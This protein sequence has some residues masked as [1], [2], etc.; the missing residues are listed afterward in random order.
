MAKKVKTAAETIA[1]VN[2]YSGKKV[3]A[4]AKSTRDGIRLAL[5]R[6]RA[7]FEKYRGMSPYRRHEIL[8]KA[9]S[10]LSKDKE[11]MAGL[12]TSE[13]GKPI[14][15]S[16]G[17]ISR[18]AFVLEQYAEESLRMNGEILPCG[19]T[20][21]EVDKK[22][23]VMRKPL[24][25][26]LCITP[27]N[28]PLNIAA[29]KVGAAFASGNAVIL[30]PSPL[31]C[32]TAVRFRDI[33]VSAGMPGELFGIVHGYK[34]AAEALAISDVDMISFTGSSKN[35]RHLMGL[36]GMKKITLELGGNA[37]LIVYDDADVEKAVK[38][39]IDQRFRTAGQRCTAAKRLFLHEKIK[40]K[41]MTRLLA[42]TRLLKAGN[43]MSGSCDLCC[44]ITEESAACVEA[45]I[46][47][48]VKKG[49]KLIYGGR[50]RGNFIAPAILESVP[51]DAD[52]VKYETF[53]PVLPVF[54]FSDTSK[55]IERVNSSGDG[56]QTGVF[57]QRLDVI[58][59]LYEEIHSGA[60]IVNDGPGFR[61]ESL[62]FGGVKESGMGREGVRYA[63]EEMTQ[64]TSLII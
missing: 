56:L 26:I 48:A 63:M 22:A 27:F 12:I 13:T 39:C 57:T 45:R 15:E 35:G 6:A 54:T 62:P 10:L 49:A 32:L 17:E 33:M 16:R 29:H 55:L 60:L 42:E 50:R 2:P 58:K 1:V 46:R 53:G 41:F 4:V 7:A 61:L 37:A 34:D 19:V 51:D 38:T 44:L 8:K 25:V 52:L 30:K 9:V 5:G 24:G 43:P 3:G 64:I 20:A 21:D 18:A 23:L 36:A 31:A 14:R 28:Y 40:H 59:R 47:D 11:K